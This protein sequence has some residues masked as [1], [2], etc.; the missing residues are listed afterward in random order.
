ME[1]NIELEA[2]KNVEKGRK[3]GIKEQLRRCENDTEK[4]PPSVHEPIAFVFNGNCEMVK[5][6]LIL[7][8]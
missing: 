6:S 3:K 4:Q 8:S 2:G 7:E 5:N 1:Y